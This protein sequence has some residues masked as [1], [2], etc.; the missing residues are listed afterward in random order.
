M[1]KIALSIAA[2]AALLALSLPGAARAQNVRSWVASTG[3]DGNPCTRASPCATFSQALSVTNAGGE[4]NC[5][6]E[7][8]FSNGGELSIAKS[9]TIDCDGVTGHMVTTAGG[10]IAIAVTAATTDRVVLRGLDISGNGVGVAGIFVNSAG[11]LQVEKC[12]VHDFS[13]PDPARVPYGIVAATINA[14]PLE[15]FV[16][17]TTV[18]NNGNSSDGG[19]ILIAP[20][21]AS[22][23]LTKAVLNRVEVRNNFFGIK[24]DATQVTGG[25]INMTIR[26]SISVGNRSN[27]IVGTGNSSGPAIVMMIDRSAA[28]HSVFGFGVIADGPK[29][30]IR[31]GGSSVTGNPTGVGATNGGTLQSFKTN[32]IKGNSLDGT[33]LPVVGLD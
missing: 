27:A 6:D 15:F 8:E 20:F 24:A 1:K 26:D 17:D 7:G 32:Q 30:F 5:A 2:L 22:N 28:S 12:V 25:V 11:A 13:N 14:A 3:N 23:S 9:I 16:S 29:T 31:L 10:A 21:L 33:P 18:M 4:I 19:G